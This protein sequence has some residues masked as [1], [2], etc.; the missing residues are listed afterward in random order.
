MRESGTQFFPVHNT[1]RPGKGAGPT[2]QHNTT[3]YEQTVV[4]GR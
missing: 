3:N 2:T 4:G 1:N